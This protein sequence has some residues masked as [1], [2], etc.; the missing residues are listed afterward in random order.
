ML[1]FSFL[2]ISKKVDSL[3]LSD[4]IVSHVS[5]P[6]YLRGSMKQY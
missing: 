6:L 4:D 2:K 1:L 5:G 3:I